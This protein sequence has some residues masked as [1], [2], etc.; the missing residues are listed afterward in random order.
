MLGDDTL[1]YGR[2]VHSL[3]DGLLKG[4]DM[5][6]NCTGKQRYEDRRS[7]PVAHLDEKASGLA[8]TGRSKPKR[9]GRKKGST[10]DEKENS[11]NIPPEP[12]SMD[13][14][15][16]ERIA[17]IQALAKIRQAAI[18]AGQ[19]AACSRPRPSRRGSKGK[20]LRKKANSD[21]IE[22]EPTQLAPIIEIQESA[23]SQDTL[24]F[25][26]DN[27][28]VKMLSEEEFRSLLL[29]LP[30]SHDPAPVPS[31]EA[32]MVTT[33]EE[34][35]FNREISHKHGADFITEHSLGETIRV[36]SSEFIVMI[37]K[38]DYCGA[39]NTET[40]FLLVDEGSQGNSETSV[41]NGSSS[42]VFG[43]SVE[44]NQVTIVDFRETMR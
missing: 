32:T 40:E 8:S 5:S 1:C 6:C 33:N 21:S 44:A 31:V 14:D 38:D 27:D 4:V 3:L 2:V 22:F 24:S 19:A 42:P 16:W 26:E 30:V 28:M 12:V 10:A 13:A 36:E 17:Q 23:L 9:R 41:G 7:S 11:E 29:K 35:H 18:R 20:K 34:G 39:I 15:Q 37:E 43:D 25:Y